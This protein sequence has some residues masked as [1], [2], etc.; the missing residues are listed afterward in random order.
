MRYVV[1]ALVSSLTAVPAQAVPLAVHP[2]PGAHDSAG[3]SLGVGYSRVFDDSNGELWELPLGEGILRKKIG[4]HQLEVRLSLSEAAFGVNLELLPEGGPVSVL[5]EPS[6]G[7]GYINQHSTL[8]SGNSISESQVQLTPAVTVVVS[9]VETFYVAPRVAYLWSRVHT[10]YTS[11][12]I[13]PNEQT[14]TGKRW[15]TGLGVGYIH[16]ARPLTLTF[17]LSVARTTQDVSYDPSRGQQTGFP[18][19]WRFMPSV[20]AQ[21]LGD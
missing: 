6:V 19:S 7:A 21:L 14:A 18:A 3:V 16:A 1:L 4:A 15:M 20:G 11:S 2:T 10:R 17:E 9:I 8:G 5:L 13:G 12:L